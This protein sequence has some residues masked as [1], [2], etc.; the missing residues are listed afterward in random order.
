MFAEKAFKVENLN[1]IGLDFSKLGVR[2]ALCLDDC[3]FGSVK[4]LFSTL[5]RKVFRKRERARLARSNKTRFI[6]KVHI[7][8]KKLGVSFDMTRT[9]ECSSCFSVCYPC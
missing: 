4:E 9:L 3:I 8:H 6:L 1:L 5:K 2:E 7:R